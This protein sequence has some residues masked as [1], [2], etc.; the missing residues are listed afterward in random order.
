[1]GQTNTKT[2]SRN[3][4]ISCD[5]D[6]SLKR[7]NQEAKQSHSVFIQE[8]CLKIFS[9]PPSKVAA[10]IY[11]YDLTSEKQLKLID[12]CCSTDVSDVRGQI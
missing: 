10:T 7:E 8:D 9:S 5:I 4:A 1:M 6:L 3:I 2:K 12:K 11:I